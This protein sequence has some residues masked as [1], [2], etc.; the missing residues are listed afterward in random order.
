MVG[1]SRSLPHSQKQVPGCFWSS[2]EPLA[3]SH[4]SFG[5]LL[6]P[7]LWLWA[8]VTVTKLPD[9]LTGVFGS[10]AC[11]AVSALPRPWAEANTW[12]NSSS[13]SSAGSSTDAAEERGAAAWKRPLPAGCQL[14][15]ST[16]NPAIPFFFS[17]SR[18]YFTFH[19]K[20]CFFPK[21]GVVR[22]PRGRRVWR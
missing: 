21:H 1:H 4:S 12:E 8:T 22:K 13:P 3:S 19:L 9:R 20:A 7:W 17:R 2:E 18:S 10:R 11:P 5:G 15:R 16:R 6:Q 14:R